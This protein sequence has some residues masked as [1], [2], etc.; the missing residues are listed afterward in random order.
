ME[1]TKELIKINI[2]NTI[3]QNVIEDTELLNIRIF[4]F[5]KNIKNNFCK[6][7]LFM[8]ND[9]Y[10]I[11][12]NDKNHTSQFICRNN[13]SDKE[14][15]KEKINIKGTYWNERDQKVWLLTIYGLIKFSGLCKNKISIVLREYV[16]TLIDYISNK[17]IEEIKTEVVEPVIL[18]IKSQVIVQEIAELNIEKPAVVYFINQVGSNKCKIGYTTDLGTR[19]ETLQTG[20]PQKL[21]VIR[22]INCE[23]IDVAQKK[24][25]YYHELYNDM[26]ITGEWFLISELEFHLLS[27]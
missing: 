12:T 9:I 14:I 5:K 24:E 26:H 7:P 1:D 4:S 27:D 13:F 18:T 3:L 2:F 23:S 17:S 16:Y 21:K 8:F 15:I 22:S 19:L 25:I 10:K 6:K 11:C 20:N